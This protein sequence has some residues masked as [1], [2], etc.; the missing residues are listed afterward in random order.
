LIIAPIVEVTNMPHA[1][2]FGVRLLTEARFDVGQ[3]FTLGVLGGHQARVAS[4]GGPALGVS[5]ACSF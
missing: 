4:S 3:G 1:D 2:R 5:A